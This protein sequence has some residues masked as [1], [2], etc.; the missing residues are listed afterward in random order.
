VRVIAVEL[1]GAWRQMEFREF[2]QLVQAGRVLDDA[3][4]RGDVLT[5]GAVVRAAELRTVAIL[6]GR[7]LPP[8]R[9][10]P[11]DPM[12]PN[13][14]AALARINWQPTGLLPPAEPP[15][16]AAGDRPTRRNEMVIPLADTVGEG[17]GTGC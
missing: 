11:R 2:T 8:P 3:L 4:V 1:D 9:L 16:A 6:R 15:S 14:D 7:P 17:R 13:I 5:G 10:I 12:E